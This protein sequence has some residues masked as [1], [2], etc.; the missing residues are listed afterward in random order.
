MRIIL[1]LLRWITIESI[2]KCDEIVGDENEKGNQANEDQ[3][4]KAECE[5]LEESSFVGHGIRI[6]A[7]DFLLE[8][9]LVIL[10]EEKFRWIIIMAK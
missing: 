5:K 4:E 9:I 2:G 1:L 10:Q 6:G 7:F 8:E 3:G